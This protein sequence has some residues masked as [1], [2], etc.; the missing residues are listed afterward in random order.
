MKSQNSPGAHGAPSIPPQYLAGPPPAPLETLVVP[1]MTQHGLGSSGGSQHR[2]GSSI[3][4]PLPALPTV[5]VP[6]LPVPSPTLTTLPT[7]CVPVLPVPPPSPP[8]PFGVSTT[9]PQAAEKV[10]TIAR[11]PRFS[12][13][14]LRRFIVRRRPSKRDAVARGLQ[15]PGKSDIA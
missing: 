12:R 7:V 9:L 2:S 3:Q 4:P 5:E 6:V 13:R 14:V 15:R 11:N 1:Q 8:P 10:A